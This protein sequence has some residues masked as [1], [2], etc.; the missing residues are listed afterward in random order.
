VQKKNFPGGGKKR[1]EQIHLARLLTLEEITKS[2]NS[3]G[4]SN[5]DVCAARGEALREMGVGVASSSIQ[6]SYT[7]FVK[8]WESLL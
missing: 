3:K 8:R 7:I 1:G 5:F 6:G 4:A 2:P